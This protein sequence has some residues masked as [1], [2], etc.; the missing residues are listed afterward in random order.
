MRHA[1]LNCHVR[2]SAT[3]GERGR[4]N[5]HHTV[6]N[7]YGGQPVTT[8]ERRW[9]DGTNTGQDQFTRKPTGVA[10]HPPVN[11]LD[12]RN[13]RRVINCIVTARECVLANAHHAV[14]DRHARQC[15]AIV[16]CLISDARDTVGDRHARQ[17]AA[18]VEC[19]IS[20]ARDT[21][22]DRHAHQRAAIA[23]CV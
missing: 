9:R 3:A 14:G 21:V 11:Q 12:A 22:G 8:R 1:A 7:F 16:E 2:Q 13:R 23:E 6:R 20:D 15:A 10:Y 19:L 18:I 17:C 4:A 5:A